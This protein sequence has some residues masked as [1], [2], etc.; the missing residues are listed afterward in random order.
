MDLALFHVVTP[1]VLPKKVRCIC[2]FAKIK[3]KHK[4]KTVTIFFIGFNMRFANQPL[5]I[6]AS[7]MLIYVTKVTLLP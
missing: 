7:G 3:E 4:I 2:A 5:P 6:G 1:K